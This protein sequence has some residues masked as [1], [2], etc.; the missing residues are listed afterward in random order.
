VERGG[1]VLRDCE[2]TPEVILLGTGSEVELATGAAEQLSAEGVAVRVVSVPCMKRFEAQTAE[3]RESVLPAAVTARL[4]IEAGV[5]NNWWGYV[6]SP[7]QVMG[8]ET[9]GESAPAKVLFEHF[10]LTV[11]NVVERAKSLL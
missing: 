9:F 8:I 11:S 6:S 1:Y 10:G 7:A 4:A 2:G 5:P 3:Y